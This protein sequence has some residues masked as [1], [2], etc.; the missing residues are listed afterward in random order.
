VH[1]LVCG[2]DGDAAWV[3]FLAPDGNLYELTQGSDLE[4][5]GSAGQ[6]ACIIC[7]K[8]RYRKWAGMEPLAIAFV[9]FF[10]VT[11]VLGPLLGAEDRP[12]WLYPDSKFRKMYGKFGQWG[13]SERR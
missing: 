9:A 10:F 6:V 7:S 8:Q 13:Y 5:P 4:P 3:H 11:I 12:E 2:D 1:G